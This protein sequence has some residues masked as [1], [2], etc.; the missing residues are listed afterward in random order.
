MSKN[1]FMA[2]STFADKNKAQILTGMGIAGFI[3]AALF[4][5]SGA[6]KAAH[7]IEDK[8]NALN[9]DQLTIGETVKTVYPC[10]IPAVSTALISTACILGATSINL[11]RTAALATA[12]S[13]SEKAFTEYKHEV[14]DKVGADKA[15]E[16][17]EAIDRRHVERKIDSSA[18]ILVGDGEILCFDNLTG[19]L[20]K[21]TKN[22][23]EKAMNTINAMLIDENT[24]TLN[25]F[26][27]EIDSPDLPT[28]KIGEDIGWD[29]EK[30]KLDIRFSTMLTRDGKP[31]LV[32]NYKTVPLYGY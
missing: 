17:D 19:R 10:F 2:L 16:I 9:V 22:T 30:S 25:V 21:S 20:F 29:I 31:C 5:G 26:Y 4:T 1:I 3:S 18:P 15:R 24:A 28:T 11:R 32:M 27:S 23:I 14:I 13:I 12:Y 8:K 7:L 6:I